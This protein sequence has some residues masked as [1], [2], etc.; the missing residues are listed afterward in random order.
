LADHV[1]KWIREQ[2]LIRAKAAIDNQTIPE[3]HPWNH[4]KPTLMQGN[5]HY[6]HTHMADLQQGT[7]R[8]AVIKSFQHTH[9]IGSM[10]ASCRISLVH[11]D[12]PES[13][14]HPFTLSPSQTSLRSPRQTS[15]KD[16]FP[17]R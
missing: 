11:Q 14:W 5:L 9:I 16:A 13:E 6:Q 17:P 8:V 3:M 10:C 12:R 15:F 1:Q 2:H 7:R 4:P